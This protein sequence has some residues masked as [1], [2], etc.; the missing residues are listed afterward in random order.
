MLAL[1]RR[2]IE[3]S[4]VKKER[5]FSFAR[6]RGFE[7]E[8][9]TLG[10]IGAGEIGRRVTHLALAFGMKVL[11]Y[12]PYQQADMGEGVRYVPLDELL[13]EAHV[14][15]LHTPLTAET[16][17]LLDREAFAKC[18]RGA[19]IINTSRGR[20]IDTDALVEALD[21]G[22]IGGAGLDVLEEEGV[23][24]K[25]AHKIVTDQ[26]VERLQNAPPEGATARGPDGIKQIERLLRN[27]RLLARP[28]VVFTPHVAFNSIETVERMQ[29]ITVKNIRAFVAGKPINVV[30][31]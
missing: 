20:V 16:F 12:D 11:A 30:T 26:I 6:W 19:I 23:M 7:L 9:K 27:E 4:K 31:V 5:H 1:S 10:V 2:L 15:S 28:N 22:M 14:I 18:R 29:A 8:N 21:A 13:G 24:R 17:H 25:D 3:V